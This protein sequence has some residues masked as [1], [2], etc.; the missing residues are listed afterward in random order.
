[1]RDAAPNRRSVRQSG[2]MLSAIGVV[3]GDIGTSPLYTSR[4]SLKAAGGVSALT[5]FGIASLILWSIIVIVTLKYVY[6]VMRAHNEGEG[7]ILALTALAT[8][9]VTPRYQSALFAIGVFGAA[10]F[11]GDS[12]IT[13]AISVLSAVEGMTLVAPHLDRWTVP[14]ALIVL[15]GLFKA[16]RSGTGSVGA[17]FGPVMLVWFAVLALL[18]LHQISMNP[19]VL[20]AVSPA[21]ALNFIGHAPGTSFVV[22]GCVFLALTGAEALYADMGHFGGGVIRRGWL[23]LV[24]PSLLLNYFGQAA[25]VLSRPAAASQPFFE[26]AP[27]W[28]LGPLVVLAPAATI[29]ASQAVISGAFSMTKQAI[30]LGFLPR[31]TVIHTSRHEIGQIYVPFINGVLFVAVLLLVVAFRSSDNLA[32]A[33][34]IAVASTMVLTP[35]GQFKLLHLWAAKFPQAGPVD[36]ASDSSVTASLVAAS[37]RR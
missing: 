2:L 8:R 15:T 17:L 32:A 35:D 24:M 28:A 18:G 16:Q 30:Q 33:Y 5:V 19:V 3:F 36:Y 1:M 10:M 20:R 4:E 7:G 13:P 11:Y 25:L 27:S 9:A 34:G 14:V 29:I 26:A 21:Y 31:M 23:T 37:R 12:M 22:L 6:Y